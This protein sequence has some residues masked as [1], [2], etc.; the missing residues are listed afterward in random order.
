MFTN[1]LPGFQLQFHWL[2]LMP[3]RF[4]KIFSF[5]SNTDGHYELVELVHG[6]YK[7]QQN[8]FTVQVFSNDAVAY[9]TE[10]G[11]SV[12]EFSQVST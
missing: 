1:N 7:M 8:T 6:M 11:V 2:F 4:D 10:A 3:S 9:S 5:S 12:A